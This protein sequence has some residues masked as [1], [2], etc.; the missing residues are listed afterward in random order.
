ME[1][2][3]HSALLRPKFETNKCAFHANKLEKLRRADKEA[4]K[5]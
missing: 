5:C 1:E 4:L 2:N 3:F